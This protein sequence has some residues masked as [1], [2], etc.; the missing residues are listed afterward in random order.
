VDKQEAFI[1]HY[2]DAYN[3]FDLEGMLRDLHPDIVFENVSGGVV[4][5][6]L[7]G[8]DEFRKQAQETAQLFTS[9]HQQIIQLAIQNNTAEVVIHYRGTLAQ[10]LPNGLKKGDTLELEGRSLF[11][12]RGNQIIGITDES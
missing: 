2:I 3:A 6:T 8:I 1:R 11:R 7:R 4:N 5:M 10:D 9:R 12:F